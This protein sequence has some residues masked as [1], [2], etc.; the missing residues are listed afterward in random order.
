MRVLIADV[1]PRVRRA[2]RVLLMRQPDLEIVGEAADAQ[3]LLLQTAEMRPDL[4]LLDWRL[5]RPVGEQLLTDL[6]EVCPGLRVVALSGRPEER[7]AALS[8]GAN[9]FACKCDAAPPLLAA[10]DDCRPLQDTAG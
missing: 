3:Q 10:I 1:E 8:A 7:G 5:T 2:L 6:Q 4:V 9:G